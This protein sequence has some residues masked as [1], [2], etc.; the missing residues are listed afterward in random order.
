MTG[1]DFVLVKQGGKIVGVRSASD[2]EPFKKDGFPEEYDS[3]AGAASYGDWQI[4]YSP[5]N[6]K[7]KTVADPKKATPA[8]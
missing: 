3:F 2:L 7:K 5:K 6:G 1:E 4:V 8:Q